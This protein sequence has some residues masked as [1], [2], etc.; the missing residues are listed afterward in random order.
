MTV[1]TK[2]EPPPPEARY[3]L[4]TADDLAGRPPLRWRVKG[5][6]PESGL[7]AIYGPSGCGKTFLTLDLAGA[8]SDACDW[9]GRR[10]H[11]CSVCYLAL[12][13]EHGISNRVQA[14]RARNGADRLSR[15]RFIAAPFSLLDVRDVPDLA[16][17]IIAAGAAG[18][19]VII[20]TLNRAAPGADENSGQDM[21]VLIAAATELQRLVG[22]LVM[23]VHHTGK[24]QGRG[25]RGHSSLIAALDAAIEV[26]RDG[27]RRE[28]KIAKAKDG[29]DGQSHPFRLEPV[30]IGTDEDG[31]AV[32]SCIVVADDQPAAPRAPRLTGANRIAWQA[33]VGALDEQGSEPAPAVVERMGTRALSRVVHEEAWRSRAYAEGISDG[34]HPSARR[35]A[36]S[37]ARRTLLDMDMVCTWDDHYWTGPNAPAVPTATSATKRDTSRPVAPATPRQSATHPFKGVAHVAPAGRVREQGEI[38]EQDVAGE[39]EIF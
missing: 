21:G 23:L 20:D 27:D 18:G 7:A 5:V 3:R 9:F 32:T 6:L 17:S 24:E 15:V 10:V 34:S 8:V 30:E 31:D 2:I 35:N 28:W 11:P 26:T 38:G 13:G 39:A 1:W 33:F 19:I 4:L 22:G 37:R 12:E 14:F 16:A 36:F 29:E 25:A